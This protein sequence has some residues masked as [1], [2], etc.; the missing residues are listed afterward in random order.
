MI[1]M[2]QIPPHARSAHDECL[3]GSSLCGLGPRAGARHG[4]GGHYAVLRPADG[5][6]P[7]LL[8]IPESDFGLLPWDGGE[9]YGMQD[10]PVERPR[11]PPYFNAAVAAV[12][13]W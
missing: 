8:A 1:L 11:R 12:R 10:P 13:L 9:N 2:G 7:Q 5:L 6:P 4:T 3:M